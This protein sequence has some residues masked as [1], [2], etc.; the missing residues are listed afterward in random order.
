MQR[1]NAN[2]RQAIAAGQQ[3]LGARAR[4]ETDVLFEDA[5]D[6]AFLF[7]F[8]IV[9]A[10]E[11]AVEQVAGFRAQEVGEAS[12]HA[13]AEI[14]AE[15]SKDQSDAARHIFA[16]MLANAF[17]D[18]K[19]AAVADGEAFT[20]AAGDIE[21]A[22]SGAIE[23]GVANKNVAAARSGRAPG[24]ADGAAGEAFADVV[25]G[26]AAEDQGDAGSEKRS[27]ALAGTAVKLLGDLAARFAAAAAAAH[28]DS[29]ESGAD[30][31]SEFWI[32]RTSGRA[33]PSGCSASSAGSSRR[34]GLCRG[35]T[36]HESETGTS[37]NGSRP[38]RAPR[39]S[40]QP[41]RSLRERAPS[42][43]RRWRISS[44]S[45]RK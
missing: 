13:G 6:P 26:L 32:G 38:E 24:N 10:H 30:A 28:E 8:Q 25:I 20:G 37:R 29:A 12:G 41:V 23:D 5:A 19:G 34:A 21:L 22:G 33:A 36:R 39:R 7:P 35:A 2:E 11:V 44:A 31:G 43:A 45:E 4:G 27:K 18:G 15:R 1:L 42:C 17:D 3:A 16:A 14:Q 9:K 40:Y